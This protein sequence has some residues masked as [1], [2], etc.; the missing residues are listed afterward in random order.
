MLRHARDNWCV[1]ARDILGFN[2]AT[3][4]AGHSNIPLGIDHGTNSLTQTQ[5]S[6]VFGIRFKW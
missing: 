2:N 4:G 6:L 3:G 1:G 5:H